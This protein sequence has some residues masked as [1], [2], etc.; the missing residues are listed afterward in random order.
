MAYLIDPTGGSSGEEVFGQRFFR[1][2][3]MD[4][5]REH[6]T[7]GEDADTPVLYLILVSGQRLDVSHIAELHARYMVV[8]AFDDPDDR[9]CKST[10]RVYIRYG[11]IFQIEVRIADRADRALGFTVREPR[12]IEPQVTGF[13]AQGPD[14]PG[15][16]G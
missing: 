5:V 10:H 7:L 4:Y 12:T 1:T 14:S 16:A 3:F 13:A 6:C 15:E 11:A 8:E 2:E 9:S